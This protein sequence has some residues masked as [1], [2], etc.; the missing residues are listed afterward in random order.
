MQVPLGVLPKS[1]M[2]YEDMTEILTHIQRYAPCQ[3]VEVQQ[4]LE[5]FVYTDYKYVTT[6]VGG[7]QL[8]T[9]RARSCV[10]MQE[11]AENNLDKLNGLLPVAEDWHAKVCFMQVSFHNYTVLLLSGTSLIRPSVIQTPQTAISDYEYHHSKYIN[12]KP[13]CLD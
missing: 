5:P 1:E 3:H 4:E 6:L 9:A 7:D 13:K 10:A 8:S 12:T 2:S 11:N